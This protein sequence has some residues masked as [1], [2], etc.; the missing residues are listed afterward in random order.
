MTKTAPT[1]AGLLLTLLVATAPAAPHAAVVESARQIP[2]AYEVDVLVVGGSTGAVSA[3]VAAAN[4]GATVFLAAPRP[5]LGDDMTA[6]M[7]LWLNDG[8][9]PRHPLAR[10]IFA[11]EGSRSQDART[12]A[13]AGVTT[14]VPPGALPLTYK[15]DVPSD[16]KHKDTNPPSR[17]ANGLLGGPEQYS[18]QYNGDVTITAELAAPQDVAEAR[19]VLFQRAADFAA[20]TV[21]IATSIDAKSWTALGTFKCDPSAEGAATISAPVAKSIRYA[22][23]QVKRTADSKRLLLSQ[24][25][26]LSKAAPAA[27]NA[28]AS[29]PAVAAAPPATTGPAKL[30]RGPIRPLH[31]K[32][33]LDDA[34]LAAKVQYLYGCYPT[35]V[36]RDADGKPCGIVMANRAGR[37]AIRAKVIIDATDRA[38]VARLAGAQ[39][40]PYPAGNVP[41]TYTIVGGEPKNADG[42]TSKTMAKGFGDPRDPDHGYELTQYTL[43]LPMPDASWRSFAAAEQVARDKTYGDTWEV[44]TDDLFQIPP[45][46]ITAVKPAAGPWTGAANLDLDALRPANVARTYVLS[47]SAGL[48]RDAA[49]QLMRPCALIEAGDRVGIAAADEAK[50]APAPKPAT[51]APAAISQ[52]ETAVGD[53]RESLANVRSTMKAVGTV[54]SP[55]RP[56]PVLGE[57]DVVVVGGGT[58]GAPAAISAARAKSKTLCLEY[59]HEL[60]GVGTAGLITSYYWGFRGGFTAEVLDGTGKWD[61]IE[62]AE[63]YRKQIRSAGGEVWFGVL[64]CGAFV[65]EGKVKGVVIATPQ[66]RGVVLAKVVIDSTGNSDVA[67]AAGAATT[68]TG[69]EEMAQQGT[70]LPPVKLNASYRNT[71]FT[72]VDETDMLDVWHVFVYAKTK[73]AGAFDL[74]KHLDTRERRRI[75]GDFTMSLPDQVNLRTYPD[76]ISLAYSNFDTHGYTVDPYLLIEHPEKK[77]IT[78]NVP[79]RCLLPK[80]LDGILVTG[81]G[82][83]VHRDAVPLTRMQPDIQN[84]GYA[85]GLI[86]AT[87]ARDD[88]AT[89]SV[90]L[91]PIQEQLVK[92]GVIPARALTDRD[93]Y[94]LPAATVEQ[95]VAAVKGGH[96]MAVIL[97]QT[98][99]ALPL[100]RKAYAAATDADK[101][102][103]A[104]V[105][106]VLGDPAGLDTII[107]ALDAAK[108]DKGWSYVGMGQFGSS[109]SPV[110]TLIVSL[111]RTRDK[112]ALPAILR[113]VAEL[114]ASHAFSHHRAVSLALESIADPAAAEP[115]AKLLAKPGITGYV[116]STVEIARTLTGSS[117]TDTTSRATSL[118]E[119]SLARALYRC[120]DKDGI[121]KKLLTDY[122]RDLRGHL[123]R[124]AAAVLEP[125]SK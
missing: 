105:L 80:G 40:G 11:E 71:D 90:N 124:H 75:V 24:V 108:W 76:T 78:V 89:R 81:L 86:A 13:P 44:N 103:Y 21:T 77:G 58:G 63:W 41:F 48:S 29:R 114:D 61:P 14:P 73:Y 70:G 37:Q 15:S 112:R 17:L 87:C 116:H 113:K 26:L 92:K 5:F 84:Q 46:P 74:G 7:R 10:A 66:G 120:G 31:I 68:H 79:Y 83:S 34:L 57:Y 62:K 54:A 28:P 125:T 111:G 101:L 22:R 88:V 115:L 82:I 19:I 97:T 122:T 119:L 3:A 47:G 53:V 12:A 104:K 16:A 2:V 100:L 55:E 45:D 56:L 85:A 117:D 99:Q 18:V 20:D 38:A 106:A 59:L 110:D 123:A 1:I 65:H 107:A 121:G 50:A 33:T 8:E 69:A 39:A 95:A 4:R 42:I 23:F 30:S 6:T 9:Q 32:K 51:V 91:K 27:A 67:A 102:T 118:R 93:S 64:G 49:A 35:E 94:P 52:G 96:G 60:G 36:L 25:M 98:E 72:I 109:L 43:Q